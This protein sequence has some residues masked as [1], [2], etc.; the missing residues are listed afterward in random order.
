MAAIGLGVGS[1]IGGFIAIGV[2][3]II[4][5]VIGSQLIGK[6]I[7]VNL[8]AIIL[9]IACGVLIAL[10]AGWVWKGLRPDLAPTMERILFLPFMI[11]GTT[12]FLIARSRGNKI[13]LIALIALSIGGGITLTKPSFPF[14]LSREKSTIGQTATVTSE[15][16]NF[17]AGP[18]TS[19]DIIK[20]LKKGDTLFI[21]G[22]VENGWAP[23]KHGK[24]SGY[25]SEELISR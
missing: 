16:L 18:S 17:R 9:G 25:V 23:V 19:H 2:G 20:T 22:P 1:F 24:D 3:G 21:T 11:V 4:G 8:F 5:W 15:S 13:L 6:S 14:S 12:L 10:L 7:Y